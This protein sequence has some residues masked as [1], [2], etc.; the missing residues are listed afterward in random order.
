M[1]YFND[2]P[3][4]SPLNDSLGY[5][6][7]AYYLAKSIAKFKLNKEKNSYV[8][9]LFGKW[10]DGKTSA[11][12]MALAYLKYLI[13]DSN[14]SIDSINKKI[15]EK[16]KQFNKIHYEKE[17]PEKRVSSLR[18]RSSLVFSVIITFLFLFI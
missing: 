4:N 13:K 11:I 12:N 6:H 14:E 7:F 9:G 8:I 16:E 17:I 18:I 2:E 5:R 10:G 3:I 15:E 1:K